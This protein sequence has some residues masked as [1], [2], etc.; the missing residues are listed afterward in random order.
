LK[1]GKDDSVAQSPTFYDLKELMEKEK[2]RRKR[3]E[4]P[5]FTL[6]RKK[7]GLGDVIN[8]GSLLGVLKVAILRAQDLVLLSRFGAH[9]RSVLAGKY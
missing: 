3:V 1:V 2:E 8:R 6:R 7:A 5:A 9:L 4:S